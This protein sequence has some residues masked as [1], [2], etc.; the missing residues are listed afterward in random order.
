[1]YGPGRWHPSKRLMHVQPSGKLCCI[2]DAK[3]T[4]HNENTTAE[5]LELY[6][7]IE[8]MS[9][10][11]RQCPVAPEDEPV[12]IV[13]F[14]HADLHKVVYMRQYGHLYGLSSAVLN[15]NRLPMMLTAS[16]RRITG[17]LSAALYDNNV[18]IDV[19]GAKGSGQQAVRTPFEVVGAELNACK[20]M[21]MG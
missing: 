9:D 5:D 17:V 12:C 8:D 1:M 4:L 19:F 15:F 13:A 3:Y 6:M 21:P 2:D 16:I 10:A 20:R 18:V 11:Y 7:G 14:F